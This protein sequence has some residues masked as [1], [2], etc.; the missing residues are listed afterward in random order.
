MTAPAVII[1]DFHA[2]AER[3]VHQR[4][5]L[6]TPGEAFDTH[7]A[8]LYIALTTPVQRAAFDRVVDAAHRLASEQYR[9]GLT[10]GR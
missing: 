3:H 10:E 8:A 9:R 1:P 4:E 5:L 6:P 2:A 7:A